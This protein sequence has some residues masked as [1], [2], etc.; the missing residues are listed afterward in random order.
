MTDGVLLRETLKDADLDKYRY[1][2]NP[3]SFSLSAYKACDIHIPQS[4]NIAFCSN[5]FPP[6]YAV[7]SLWMKHTKDPLIL[8]F[9]L[10]Y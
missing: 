5:S 6:L 3:P 8:M 1:A 10:A 2:V 7:S 9:C 4:E